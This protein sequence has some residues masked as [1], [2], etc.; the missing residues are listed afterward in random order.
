M[1]T[2]RGTVVLLTGASGGI[3]SQVARRLAER[4]ARVALSGRRLEPLEELAR[5]IE[6][7]GGEPPEV[8]VEDIGQPG[9]A[10][11]LADRATA[12]LG[13]VDVLINCAGVAMR[14]LTWVAGDGIEARQ[15]FETNVWS[16]VAL[17]AALAPGMVE[18]GGGTI[19]NVNSIAKLSGGAQAG[20]YSASRSALAVMTQAMRAELAPR[21]LRIVEVVFGVIDTPAMRER[22]MRPV[23][24]HLM[25]KLDDAVETIVTAAAGGTRDVAFYPSMLRLSS[26]I[27]V[28]PSVKASEADL[29][30][31]TVR[32]F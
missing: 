11:Q 9:G 10:R 24:K 26:Y 22:R 30:D 5:E 8:L 13:R 19:V 4:G 23:N 31:R 32:L 21:G 27:P 7:A 1:S 12:S 28:Q 14:G 20:H 6:A 16:P 3:G 17:A 15:V 18:R 2:M 29:N 25:G